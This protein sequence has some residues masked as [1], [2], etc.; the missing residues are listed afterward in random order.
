MAD[1]FRRIQTPLDPIRHSPFIKGPRQIFLPVILLPNVF[2]LPPSFGQSFFCQ[3]CS[4]RL[5]GGSS[6][7]S[8]GLQ[9]GP[10]LEGKLQ[11]PMTP[12]QIQL[13]ADVGSVGFYGAMANAEFLGNL[14]AG[15]MVGNAPE[16]STLC[17]R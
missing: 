17:R 3:I 7:L 11:Q 15:A 16:N 5:S 4:R 9:F 8:V 10:M 14:F 1:A 13:G 12:A 2:P 6:A